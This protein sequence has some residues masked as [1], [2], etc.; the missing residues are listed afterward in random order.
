M[1]EFLADMPPGVH[2][3]RVSGRLSGDDL[4][5]MRPLIDELA[6][7]E[8]IRIVEVIADDYQGFGS[9]GLA[10][11]LK[12]GWNLIKHRAAIKRIPVV[13]DLAWAT[14]TLH[15][16]AWMVPGEMRVFSLADLEWATRWAAGADRA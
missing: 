4:R 2:G 9:G 15:A 12:V 10:E 11:D 5:G 13:T 7:A 3:I 1:I 6:G 16:I 8:Q 14:H